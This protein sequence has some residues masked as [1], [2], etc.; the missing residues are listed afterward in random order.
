MANNKTPISDISDFLP[1]TQNNSISD[2]VQA[3]S[4]GVQ[5]HVEIGNSINIEA[6]TEIA[7]KLVNLEPLTGSTTLRLHEQEQAEIEEYI[8]SLKKKELIQRKYQ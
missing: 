7:N 4:D 8:F 3:H 1:N 6:L 5:A 2:G